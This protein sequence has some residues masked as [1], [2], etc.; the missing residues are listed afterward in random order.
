MNIFKNPFHREKQTYLDLYK[1]GYNYQHGIGI[2]KNVNKAFIYYQKSAE[3]GN[4]D[5]LFNLGYCYQHG[6]GVK[7][8]EKKARIILF[9]FG[10]I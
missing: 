2:K 4:A 5:G 6:F 9:G 8:N 10:W 3:L 7:K 1:L